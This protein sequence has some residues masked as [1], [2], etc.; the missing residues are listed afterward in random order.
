[1]PSH[2]TALWHYLKFL[3]GINPRTNALTIRIYS[4]NIPLFILTPLLSKL[5]VYLPQGS[6][7]QGSP[8]YNNL[9]VIMPFLAKWAPFFF[10]CF[11]LWTQ[12]EKIQSPTQM[13]AATPPTIRPT[14]HFCWYQAM[15]VSSPIH[16]KYKRYVVSSRALTFEQL[17]TSES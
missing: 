15:A 12:T 10:A 11:F 16:D 7:N 4:Y 2:L 9:P 13:M 5:I 17:G 14:T 1:M 3:A 6:D 8:V